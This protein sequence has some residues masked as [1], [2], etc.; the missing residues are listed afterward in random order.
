MEDCASGTIDAVLTA[1]IGRPRPMA[2]RGHRRLA[3]GDLRTRDRACRKTRTSGRL[4]SYRPR[5]G[6]GEPPAGGGRNPEV[7]F[8]GQQRRS[9]THASLT[10]PRARLY[11]KGRGQKAVLGYMGHLLTGCRSTSSGGR[12]PANPAPGRSGS[13]PGPSAHPVG[14]RT[15]AGG[16][17][18]GAPGGLRVHAGH[19]RG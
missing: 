6:S 7:D 4:K 1:G 18:A 5:D 17:P 3:P 13:R 15:R 11:R 8:R 9:E 14:R 16:A 2:R 12:E 10:D 19:G